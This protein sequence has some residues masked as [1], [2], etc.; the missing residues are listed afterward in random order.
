MRR[1][2]ITEA[3]GEKFTDKQSAKT[4]AANFDR[5][6]RLQHIEATTKKTYPHATEVNSHPEHDE[7]AP[8]DNTRKT[9]TVGRK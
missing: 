3:G 6:E 4:T 7:C 2:T 5:L 8:D 9:R 1:E